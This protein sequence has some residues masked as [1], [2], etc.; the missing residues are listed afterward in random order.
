MNLE[1]ETKSETDRT[2]EPKLTSVAITEEMNRVYPLYIIDPDGLDLKKEGYL[3]TKAKAVKLNGQTI[4]ILVEMQEL[5]AQ[6]NGFYTIRVTTI[7][8]A[9]P[10]IILKHAI[11]QYMKTGCRRQL[12][13]TD[14]SKSPLLFHT[15]EDPEKPGDIQAKQEEYYV[16]YTNHLDPTAAC[17]LDTLMTEIKL[18]LKKN[19]DKY[20]QSLK[21]Q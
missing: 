10:D 8:T 3:A 5:P 7:K 20:H 21:Q 15:T 11:R 13:N 2:K 17:E 14:N 1:H 4:D 16:I 19:P 18:E 12:V 6:V 9:D